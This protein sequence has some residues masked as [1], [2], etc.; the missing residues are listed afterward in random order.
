MVTPN[1]KKRDHGASSLA[2]GS[3]TTSQDCPLDTHRPGYHLVLLS[4]VLLS[5][6]QTIDVKKKNPKNQKK[7][8]LILEEITAY[9][10]AILN[11]H[12]LGMQV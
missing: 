10:G 5:R 3:P 12:G 1:T 7:K 4:H 9:F 11:E 2:A 6:F 8:A